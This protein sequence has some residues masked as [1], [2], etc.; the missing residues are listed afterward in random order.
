[1]KTVV[2]ALAILA[3]SGSLALAEGSNKPMNS[4]KHSSGTVGAMQNTQGD[5]IA[6]NP[7]QVKAQQGGATKASPGTVGAAP[8]T[9]APSSNPNH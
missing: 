7:E 8:G 9:N 1:M 4:T 2:T 3:L 5:G 6:T